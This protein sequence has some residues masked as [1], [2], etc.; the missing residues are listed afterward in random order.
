MAKIF[1]NL[2]T[3]DEHYTPQIQEKS[4]MNPASTKH[5]CTEAHQNTVAQNQGKS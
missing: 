4:S 5:M 1:P 2:Y 3:V